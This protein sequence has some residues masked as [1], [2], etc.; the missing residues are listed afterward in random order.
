MA[1]K[2]GAT[3]AWSNK[4]LF[5]SKEDRVLFGLF[6][7]LGEYLGFNSAILRLVYV[8]LTAFTGFV[9]GIAAYLIGVLVV[10]EK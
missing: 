1:V 5:R 7:G 2:K 4:P 10:P 3:T 9:P 6:G 8:A